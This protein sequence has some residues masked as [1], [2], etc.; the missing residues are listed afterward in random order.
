MNTIKFNES[1]K[2]AAGIADELKLALKDNNQSKI[3]ELVT[4]LNGMDLTEVR[5]SIL[6]Q[7]DECFEHPDYQM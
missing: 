3:N 5:Q 4:V 6:D 2:K 7:L 1:E